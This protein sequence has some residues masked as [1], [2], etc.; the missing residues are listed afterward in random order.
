MSELCIKVC[1]VCREKMVGLKLC[2]EPLCGLKT[3]LI[4]KMGNLHGRRKYVY[5]CN[6]K[7]EHQKNCPYSGKFYQTANGS[8]MTYQGDRYEYK[9]DGKLHN[10]NGPAVRYI[11][12]DSVEYWVNGVKTHGNYS[13]LPCMLTKTDLTKCNCRPIKT[14]ELVED[15][16]VYIDVYDE[17]ST[18]TDCLLQDKQALRTKEECKET[19][20]SNPQ[21]E[22]ELSMLRQL[23]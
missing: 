13:N 2:S 12:D 23:N 9:R 1:T 11:K 19:D 18:E 5:H 22:L 17:E 3:A 6:L 4:N 10:V 21:I 15:K 20:Y 16:P 8:E 14:N 7:K